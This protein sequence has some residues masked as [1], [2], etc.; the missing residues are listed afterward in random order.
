MI[1]IIIIFIY[2]TYNLKNTIKPVSVKFN[3]ILKKNLV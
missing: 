3:I 1:K 2:V